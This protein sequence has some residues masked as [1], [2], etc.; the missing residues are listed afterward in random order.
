MN[1]ANK[2]IIDGNPVDVATNSIMK[3]YFGN[4]ASNQNSTRSVSSSYT[5]IT[6]DSLEEELKR[7]QDENTKLMMENTR[8]TAECT[9]LSGF[10]EGL[11]Q[12]KR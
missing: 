2:S 9:R 12:K 3:K 11:Q 8:L 7:L 10:I 4:Q 1:M 5:V 6:D